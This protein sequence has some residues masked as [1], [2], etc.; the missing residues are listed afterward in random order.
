MSELLG[1]YTR[2]CG[3]A[4][5]AVALGLLPV[6]GARAAQSDFSLS[7]MSQRPATAT[8]LHLGIVYRKPSDPNGKPS[9]IRHLV[10]A[11]PPGTRFNLAMPRCTATDQEIM[12][13]GPSACPER[14]KVGEGTLTAI[15]GFGPPVDPYPTDVTI[16]NTGQGILEILT[17]QRTG[18]T[19]ADDRIQIKGNVMIGN[20]PSVPG[21][22]PDGQTAV[23]K[24]DF[25]F[26]AT[27]RFVTTPPSCRH[28]EWASNA[29]FTFADGTTQHVSS[30]TPCVARADHVAPRIAIAGVPRRCVR[31]AFRVRVRIRER[32]TLR[33]VSVRLDGRVRR[34]TRGTRITFRVPVGALRP[35]RHLLSIVARDAAGNRARRT[36]RFRRC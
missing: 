9:P 18:G 5:A 16:F 1:R 14:S 8:A 30:T 4:G 15:T 13:D 3:A 6:G 23:R 20:P 36:A 31:R 12:A 28:H 26:P 35:G 22:P 27:T 7:F 24:I 2:R 29:S 33:R 17:D 10:T 19:L 11:A 25:T 32:S 34:T 21:G